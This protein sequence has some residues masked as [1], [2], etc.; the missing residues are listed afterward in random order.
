MISLV[1]RIV[2]DYR[3][4][5]VVGTGS[6][7]TVYRA[8]HLRHGR[9][10]AVKVVSEQISADPSFPDR[11]RKVTEAARR[12]HHPHIVD[13]EDVGEDRRQF[14][15]AMEF[16]EFGTVRALQERRADSLP[17]ERAVEFVRQAA[18]ALTAAH[19]QGV[20][21]RDLK[22]ENL[23]LAD[24]G[25]LGAR[26]GEGGRIK[27]ADW[28]LAHLV[29]TG[30]TVVGNL[31]PGSPPYMSPEQCRG[32]PVDARSDLYSLGVVLYE[33]AV[34]YPPFQVTSLADAISKHLEAKP[35]A[36]RSVAPTIPQPLEAIIMRALA[37]SN[38]E[39]FQSASEMAAALRDVLTTIRP[40]ERR[41]MAWRQEGIPA[42]Q[43]PDDV[44]RLR[45]RFR[46][47]SSAA[48]ERPQPDRAPA[49]APPAEQRPPDEISA[50]RRR[51]HL[52]RP[53]NVEAQPTVPGMPR[54][55]NLQAGAA[56]PSAPP[57]RSPEAPRK[58]DSKRIRVTLDRP[59]L[60]L[61][62]GQPAVV[63]ITIMNG[64]KTVD[65]FPTTVEGVPGN[66][67]QL[68]PS[69]PQLN[70][71]ERASFGVTVLVPRAAE[72]HA[73]V[74]NVTFRVSGVHNAT[75]F[76][77]VGSE[78]TV[79]PFAS[80]SVS[81]APSRAHGW[82]QATYGV[83][84]RN[85]GN[86]P[87]R[88]VLAGNDDEQ[89][90]QYRFGDP[91]VELGPGSAVT[92]RMHVVAPRRWIGSSDA[93]AFTVRADPQAA[94]GA[95]IAAAPLA[96]TLTAGQFVRRPIIPLWVPPVLAIAGIAAFLLLKDRNTVHLD[97]VPARAVVH[98]GEAFK[99]T[100]QVTNAKGQALSDTGLTWVSG[101]TTIAS[102][103]RDG[104]LHGHALGT[105]SVTVTRGKFTKT[106]EIEVLN[107]TVAKLDVSPKS[108]ALPKG[109]SRKL[110]AT[111]KDAGDN[112]L[113]RDVSWVS[114]DPSVVT[115]G[116]D[117]QIV[118]KDTGKA[119]VTASVE[120]KIATVDVS[121]IA[122]QG[123]AGGA[124]GS[125]SDECVAYDH[126]ALKSMRDK[127]LGWVV[128][129][130][131]SFVLRFDNGDDGGKAWAVA[132]TFKTHCYLGRHNSRPNH[133][134]FVNEY[135]LAPSQVPLATIKNE[136]CTAFN[137]GGLR[138][139]DRGPQGFVLVD[140]NTVLLSADTQRDADKMKSI[141]QQYSQMC[142]VGRNNKHG[143]T[144]HRD[145]MMQ[146]WK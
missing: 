28:G 9:L 7:G 96:P 91:H 73:G 133:G 12:L 54:P 51:I 94:E 113:P 39:R 8:R 52:G 56:A 122:P 112:A 27:V 31:A 130:A 2:G 78:W 140:G 143:P 106:A 107:A 30:L 41:K 36:P 3:L 131:H 43:T 68:P 26:G 117:G 139:E 101:D 77:T 146:Y 42:S 22:P 38:T 6:L 126:A 67:V 95:V 76:S 86:F 104:I 103:G 23:M 19:A 47:D 121:V 88:Y 64:G 120:G 20:L 84:L 144:D 110:S 83:T 24:P 129:D 102:I 60:T 100:A 125:G 13:I 115:V 53:E 46:D 61:V 132:R 10:T 50:G 109:A 55:A 93:R 40:V 59:L 80:S 111:A 82:R 119:T 65:T 33:L 11:F 48:P 105:T 85:D 21:H 116:G 37:K 81:L 69:P 15:I 87:A 142:F 72:S 89:V 75:D 118:G 25:P 98:V 108:L 137:R 70:P 134:A 141:A 14:F 92:T 114:S 63:R 4:E 16:I 97:L 18:E 79:L 35:P 58:E 71:G 45:V 34:G 124:G 62:P 66:W 90:L 123:G 49:D 99:L 138:T 57:A 145:F 128:T 127:A 29:E 17:L 44:G 136:D 135:W 32:A 1:G 5:Q 74:Y